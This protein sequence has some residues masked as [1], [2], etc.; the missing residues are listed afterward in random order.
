MNR[1]LFVIPPYITF[2]SFV[3]PSFNDGTIEKEDG[4]YRNIV[5]DVP[6]GLLSLSAY[7][8]KHTDA[9]IQL[10][11]F[12]IV[13]YKLKSF[14]YQSFSEL[15]H[16]VLTT[17]EWQD[18]DPSIIGISALFVPAYYNALDL[19]SAARKIFP[20]A[21]ILGGGGIP[22]SM[23]R[24]ILGADTSFDALCYG[25]GEKPL[26]KLVKATD[27]NEILNMHASW[28]TKE[29]VRNKQSFQHDFIEDLD[30]IPFFDYDII[31]IDDYRLSPVLSTFPLAKDKMHSLP[32]MTSLGCPHRCCF[33]SSHTV[34][35]RKMRFYSL[36]RVRE[37]L[38]RLREQ[39]GVK[40]IVFYDDHFMAKRE[41]VFEIIKII[42]ELKLTA[43]FPASLTLYALDRKML[44]ALKSIGV[45]QLVLS[46]ESGSDRVLKEIMH[47]PLNLSTVKRVADDCQQL[48]IATDVAILIGLPGETKQD[49]EDT[50]LFLKTINATWFRIN[51]ATPLA[52]SEMLDICIE[53]D[54]LKGDYI[55]CD[56]KRAIIETD[57][58]TPEY[59]Q[60]KAYSLNLELN[61]VENS[62]F[63]SGHYETALK[64]FM[65]AI[66]V[67]S[68]HALAL[69]FAAKCFKM[70]NLDEQYEAYKLR[71]N[72]IIGKSTFW[73]DYADKFNLAALE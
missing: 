70:M 21:L 20:N 30:E 24:E 1:I 16:D 53:N 66:R 5:A 51:V 65:N 54:Y 32:I 50:R 73:R 40:T 52:G 44:E 58:F 11:D 7:L 23:Y 28:I 39:Y 35:G 49:I 26:L 59:I 71:Y 42:E 61:F 8:K 60:E 47:K 13:L 2:E 34:H 18:F 72:Q 19:G 55:D 29:K 12:N 68:D 38:T 46:V 62:D 9:Q 17:K 31:D 15:F 45:N 6:M 43:F 22:T 41:R 37:D 36:R 67:K 56:F 57:D 33:C 3:H 63:R 64:G 14:G 69:Y 25:E 27:R 4:K 48:G 10:I